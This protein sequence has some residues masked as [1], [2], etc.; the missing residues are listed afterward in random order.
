MINNGVI[1][2]G[3]I[4]TVAIIFAVIVSF[5]SISENSESS[6]TVTNGNHLEK[7]GDVTTESEMTLIQ[8]FEKASGWRWEP[9]LVSRCYVLNLS[10]L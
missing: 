10:V 6:F 1:I 3:S 8:L 4:A 7:L 2:G 9:F 5:N